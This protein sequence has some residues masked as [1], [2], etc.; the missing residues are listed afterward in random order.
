[1]PDPGRAPSALQSLADAGPG[2]LVAGLI[3]ALA[4]WG[5]ALVFLRRE[6]SPPD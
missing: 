2:S 5:A 4:F 3:V 1:M 6:L